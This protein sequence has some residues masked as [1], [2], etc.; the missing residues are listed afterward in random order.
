MD[1]IVINDLEVFGFHGVF[2]EEKALGQ[3]FLISMEL[4]LDTREAALTEDLT[5]SVHYGELCHR[6]E[7]EFKKESYDLI[8]TVSEKIAEFILGEYELVKAVKVI[9]KKPWAPIHRNLD[10]VYIE[11]YRKWHRAYLG[12]GSNMGD[13]EGNINDALNIINQSSHTKVVKCSKLITTEPWGYTDQEE[14]INGA[15]EIRTLLSPKELVNFLLQI[16]RDLKRERIIKWGPRTL[17]LDVLLYDDLISD[18]E[19]IVI[20]HPRMHLRKFVMEPLAEIA[21]Y[22]VH[23]LLRKRIFEINETLK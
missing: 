2:K 17:D 19:D 21:P 10:T 4:E 12:M 15:C 22:A 20:P 14:F 23:P 9:L 6:V 1:K 11:I 18:D 8:E 16:E 13:K 3:K 5:K 7:E